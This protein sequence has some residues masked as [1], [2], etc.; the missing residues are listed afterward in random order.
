MNFKVLTNYSSEILG[1][2]F[3]ISTRISALSCY[4]LSQWS[5]WYFI[6]KWSSFGIDF[7]RRKK[8]IMLQSKAIYNTIIRL[9]SSLIRQLY[10]TKMTHLHSYLQRFRFVFIAGTRYRVKAFAFIE[11][12]TGVNDNVAAWNWKADGFGK[13]Y[14]NAGSTRLLIIILFN[15]KTC[16]L[17][18]KRNRRTLI[19]I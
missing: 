3:S 8:N 17:L 12:F 16:V 15:E 5:R 11:H 19:N 4:L 13:Q 9:W 7:L 18:C 14:Y 6:N 2:S 1:C 10:Y